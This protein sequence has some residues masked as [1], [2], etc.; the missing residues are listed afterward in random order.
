MRLAGGPAAAASSAG[1]SFA[2]GPSASAAWT[3]PAG[4]VHENSHFGASAW[5]NQIGQEGVVAGKW[6]AYVCHET[7][8][9]LEFPGSSVTCT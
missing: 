5:C 9:G 2:G 8:H 4:Y 6:T 3:P 7:L 1:A